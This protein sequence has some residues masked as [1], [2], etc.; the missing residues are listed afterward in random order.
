MRYFFDEPLQTLTFLSRVS[1][2]KPLE[3]YTLIQKGYVCSD[4]I[5]MSTANLSQILGR[6]IRSTQW[7]IPTI[8]RKTYYDVQWIKK[9][10]KNR[11]LCSIFEKEY[12]VLLKKI[13]DP[14]ILLYG[15]GNKSALHNACIAVVGTRKPD[16][17]G[18]NASYDIGM[19]IAKRGYSLVSGLAYGIDIATHRG[20]IYYGSKTVLKLSKYSDNNNGTKNGDTN[21][22]KLGF[23]VVV[24]GTG[25]DNIYPKCHKNDAMRILSMGGTIISEIPPVS[26]DLVRKHSFIGRNRIISGLSNDVIIIQCPHKSGA[27]ATADFALE[28]GR[29]VWV[30]KSGIHKGF[31]GT[32]KLYD[33]GAM[34]FRKPEEL[35]L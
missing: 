12:P 15:M 17:K 23:G 20:M 34:V 13:T 26:A 27:L 7:I 2:L 33:E 32:Q 29:T 8:L 35:F 11:W 25:I 16:Y 14:P 10:N 18:R 28:Q 21:A 31:E 24:L 19:Y 3:K 9:D 6:K 4:F 5:K 30:H 22:I 1:F